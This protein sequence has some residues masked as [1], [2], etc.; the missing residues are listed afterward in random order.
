M[1]Q[2]EGRRQYETGTD[3]ANELAIAA[4]LETQWDV[5]LEKLPDYYFADFIG[6]DR[7]TKV[8]RVLAEVKVR[9]CYSGDFDSWMISLGKFTACLGIITP[10]H[11]KFRVILHLHDGMFVHEWDD[12]ARG[13]TIRAGG[14]NKKRDA[15]DREPY[16]FIPG[17]FFRKIGEPILWKGVQTC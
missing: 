4:F 16:V 12:C 9:D 10:F 14:R 11:L 8:A 13:Y 1:F 3:L 5:M 2:G 6:Y 7:R 17:D 15:Q